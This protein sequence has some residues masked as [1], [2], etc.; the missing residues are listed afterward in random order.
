MS[1][2]TKPYGAMVAQSTHEDDEEPE[3]DTDATVQTER[4]GRSDGVHEGEIG[5]ADNEVGGPVA[6]GSDRAADAAL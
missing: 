6:A 5:G 4:A 1:L 3:N 2:S